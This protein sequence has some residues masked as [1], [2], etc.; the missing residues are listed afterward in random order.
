M[1]KFRLVDPDSGISPYPSDCPLFDCSSVVWQSDSHRVYRERLRES[2]VH[3]D[4]TFRCWVV[5][6]HSDVMGLLAHEESMN[7]EYDAG[8]DRYRFSGLEE[9][10]KHAKRCMRSALSFDRKDVQGFVEGWMDGFLSRPGSF[11]AVGDFGVLLPREFMS[12][13]LGFTQDDVGRIVAELSSERTDIVSS[14]ESVLRVIRDILDDVKSAPRPGVLGTL[15]LAR[16]GERMT[17]DQVAVMFR[18]LWYAGTLTLSTLLPSSILW[19]CRRP[20]IAQSLRDTP[21]MI[22]AFISETIRLETPIQ[23]VPRTANVDMVI[24]G[25][26][27]SKGSLLRLCLAAANR[28]PKVFP[29]PDAMDLGRPV[30]RNL[31]MGYGDHFCLGALHARTIAENSIRRLL[32]ASRSIRCLTPESELEYEHSSIFRALKKLDVVLE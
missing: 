5:L 1:V 2:S 11:D 16:E 17:D 21:E 31:A 30:Y 7:R 27:V 18:H 14:M 32:Q 6:G 12:F 15:V 28:D 23:F 9:E 10:A 4:P 29:Y 13:L 8:F 24:Q 19:L 20:D 25:R 22:P 3:F 26:K